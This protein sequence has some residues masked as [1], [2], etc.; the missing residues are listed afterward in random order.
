MLLVSHYKLMF[1][2]ILGKAL[3]KVPLETL[4]SGSKGQD[5]DSGCV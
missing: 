2:L 1:D 4:S 5:L 3:I